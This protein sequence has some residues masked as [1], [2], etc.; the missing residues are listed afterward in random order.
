MRGEKDLVLLFTKHL[1]IFMQRSPMHHEN[2]DVSPADFSGTGFQHAKDNILRLIP[3][4]VC[5]DLIPFSVSF[6]DGAFKGLDRKNTVLK[7]L[8]S[9]KLH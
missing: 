8:A 3:K 5:A 2:T 9:F 1:K 4:G 6:T 7:L